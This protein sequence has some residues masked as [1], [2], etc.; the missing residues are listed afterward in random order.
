MT[1][2]PTTGVAAGRTYW[3]IVL[4][5]FRRN[6][7]ACVSLWVIAGLFVLAVYAPFLSNDRPYAFRGSMPSFYRFVFYQVRGGAW[8]E[9]SSAP[10]RYR[11]EVAAWEDGSV[12]L[13]QLYR[14]VTSDGYA[15]VEPLF[16]ALRD[17]AVRD[18]RVTAR[19]AGLEIT[20][21]EIRRQAEA[22]A[23]RLDP[24][25]LAAGLEELTA[26]EAR[27]PTL[28]PDL[29]E[30]RLESTFAGLTLNL[31][32]L[33]SQL[34]TEKTADAA[35]LVA[36]SRRFVTREF[37]VA[38]GAHRD[39]LDGE[40]QTLAQDFA[41]K[42][43]P[44]TAPLQARVY[45]PV[46]DSLS[47]WDLLLLPAV[48]GL[49]FLWGPWRLLRR[50]RVS[51]QAILCLLVPC[52]LVGIAWGVSHQAR[53]DIVEFNGAVAEDDVTM[54][55]SVWPPHRHRYD[56]PA[57]K[58][59]AE[60]RLQ[61]P[62]WGH[63]LGTDARGKDL[64]SQLLW[65]AR[66]S[67]AVGF[68]SAAIAM[69]IGVFTGALAGYFRGVTDIVIS[70]LIEWMLCIPVLFAVLAAVAVLPPN[71]FYVMLVIGLFG[72]MGIARLTRAEFLRLANQDFVVA[73][74]ALGASHLRII[75]KH[76]LPNSLAPVLVSGAFAVAAGILIESSLSFLGFGVRAPQVSWGSILSY[77]R[78]K[79]EHL[80]LII[81][82]G[83]LIFVTVTAYNLL[84]EGIR[85]AMDP[86]LKV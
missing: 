67:L 79:P 12:T 77:S 25:L 42:F 10:S 63:P 16:K 66:I 57:P 82:P 61:S 85:D 39:E 4:A 69:W 58:N 27:V 53:Y 80:S 2:S 32:R 31:D 81:P 55:W 72:W 59:Y 75:V 74:R 64:L 26:I 71:I 29:Y 50:R 7:L 54:E 33:C 36:A 30:E 47:G 68:V 40:V 28:L 73:A 76:V 8:R 70:R 45:Y 41:A 6:R 9:F 60:A 86:R 19:W 84:G 21:S 15:R 83:F 65:G 22:E 11:G 35:A 37:I 46:F 56:E 1:E 17:A 24:R 43:D 18:P 23:L 3:D 38:D 49:L 51:M 62:S 5:G 34:S 20:L 14:Q 44:A 13:A 52:A 78:E 48:A